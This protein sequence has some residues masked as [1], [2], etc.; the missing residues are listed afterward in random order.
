MVEHQRGDVLF[1]QV[2][3]RKN[4]REWTPVSDHGTMDRRYKCMIGCTQMKVMFHTCVCVSVVNVEHTDASPLS[5]EPSS[6][7]RYLD[8]TL[9]RNQRGKLLVGH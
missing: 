4:D 3:R 5:K 8:I 1:V 2:I 6:P 7:T 9:K